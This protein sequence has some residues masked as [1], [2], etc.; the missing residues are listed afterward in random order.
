MV[1]I[2][3]RSIDARLAEHTAAVAA[4]RYMENATNIV[5]RD[6]NH[7]RLKKLEEENMSV[8]CELK[9][10]NIKC[11]KLRLVHSCEVNRFLLSSVP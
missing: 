8:K 11:Q 2:G 4:I 7:H 1:I 6:L 5:I 9:R 3:V 10:A